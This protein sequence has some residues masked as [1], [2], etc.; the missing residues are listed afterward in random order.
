MPDVH[1]VNVRQHSREHRLREH[2]KHDNTCLPATAAAHDADI[3]NSQK[4]YTL[5]SYRQRGAIGR[6][7]RRRTHTFPR[8][9]DRGTHDLPYDF[10]WKR[11]VFDA[12]LATVP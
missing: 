9:C 12:F 6:A 2:L 3:E 4:R 5:N 7:C 10:I 8:A 11:P 1:L